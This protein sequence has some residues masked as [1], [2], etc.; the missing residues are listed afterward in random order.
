MIQVLTLQGTVLGLQIHPV[1]R[2]TC[3]VSNFNS[4]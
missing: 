1:V 4:I 2:L 3:G